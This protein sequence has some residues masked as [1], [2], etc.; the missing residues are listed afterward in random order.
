MQTIFKDITIT[1]F[2]PLAKNSNTTMINGLNKFIINFNQCVKGQY[3]LLP[4]QAYTGVHGKIK[5]RHI[6]GE[7]IETKPS[8][9]LFVTEKRVR[10]S[11]A[12]QKIVLAPFASND[13]I[14]TFNKFKYSKEYV[15]PATISALK[16][17]ISVLHNTCNTKFSTNPD[18]L[19]QG[20]TCTNCLIKNNKYKL[21]PQSL[22]NV[23]IS[24]FSLFLLNFE[25]IAS[26]EYTISENQTYTGV[27]SKLKI[28][29]KQCNSEY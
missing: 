17:N 26:S 5:L 28:V 14:K 25:K 19:L 12:C 3:E 9:L 10:I 4:K 22:S 16:T 8:K 2:L 1:D 6:C 7:V 29:H 20:E 18:R 21:V 15:L 24:N 11:C 13:F 27:R 23:H